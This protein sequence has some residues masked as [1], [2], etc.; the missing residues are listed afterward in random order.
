V[1]TVHAINWT[2]AP[3]VL[4]PTR[5]GTDGYRKHDQ[6]KAQDIPNQVNFA[7]FERFDSELGPSKWVSLFWGCAP[8]IKTSL[9][10]PLVAHGT[11]FKS[12]R[13]LEFSASMH[14]KLILEISGFCTW[15][16]DDLNKSRMMARRT[17]Q[18]QVPPDAK[19]PTTP[20]RPCL[21]NRN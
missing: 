6:T 20:P 14:S 4:R 10:Q 7:H 16:I 11:V 17:I 8:F 13:N 9:M 18:Q 19:P 5:T 2:S 21:F 1:Q 3:Q 15:W 12:V